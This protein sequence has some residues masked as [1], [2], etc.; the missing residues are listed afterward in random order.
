VLKRQVERG[1]QTS[2]RCLNPAIEEPIHRKPG[3][4]SKR[5]QTRDCAHDLQ[6][7]VHLLNYNEREGVGCSIN[8]YETRK[9]YQT[10]CYVNEQ[11]NGDSAAMQSTSANLQRRGTLYLRNRKHRV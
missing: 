4:V 1:A 10:A 6:H 5:E 11:D 2:L 8:R 9:F 3:L 7:S